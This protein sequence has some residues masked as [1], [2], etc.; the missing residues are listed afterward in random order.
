[1]WWEVS[2]IPWSQRGGEEGAHLSAL[3]ALQPHWGRS[4]NDPSLLRQ[5]LRWHLMV[6]QK[7]GDHKTDTPAFFPSTAWGDDGEGSGRR[8][9]CLVWLICRQ[10]NPSP[11]FRRLETD[12]C[13]C[14]QCCALAPPVC[15]R[16][17]CVSQPKRTDTSGK[18]GKSTLAMYHTKVTREKNG[19]K[20]GSITLLLDH[21]VCLLINGAWGTSCCPKQGWLPRAGTSSSQVSCWSHMSIGTVCEEQ[22]DPRPSLGHGRVCSPGMLASWYYFNL[23][24]LFS[25]F[26][27]GLFKDSSPNPVR[28]D[29]FLPKQCIG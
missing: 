10:R 29:N 17:L 12:Y 19:F 8:K 3:P 4:V 6:R 11:F 2:A 13:W 18:G 14:R 23:N 7:G 22:A 1:M 16:V 9:R 27:T 24:L 28:D 21:V 26:F 20:S 15:G 5:Q 25:L